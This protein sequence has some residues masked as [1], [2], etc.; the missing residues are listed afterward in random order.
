MIEKTAWAYMWRGAYLYRTYIPGNTIFF[1]AWLQKCI[2]IPLTKIYVHETTNI[3]FS[4]KS[5]W[6]V[7][8]Q[9]T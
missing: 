7:K 6:F 3:S 2:C 1:K 9:T 5:L 8:L 4:E